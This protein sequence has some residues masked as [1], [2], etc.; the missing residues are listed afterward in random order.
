M[1]ER[2]KKLGSMLK[3][4][5]TIPKAK[6]R[7]DKLVLYLSLI[8][9]FFFALLVR[10]YPYFSHGIVLKAYDPYFQLKSTLYIITHG[11]AAWF[12]WVE[13]PPGI[14]TWYPYG[15]NMPKT[16][17]PGIP[18]TAAILYF[19][20]RFLGIEVDP[21]AICFFFP[22]FMGALASI[23]MFFL[24]KEIS[25]STKAGLLSA[26]FLAFIPGYVQ[27]TTA[28]FFD[29]EAIGILLI[30]VTL[31][32]FIRSLKRESLLSGIM[33]GLILGYLS[34]SWGA[35]VYVYDLL[36][37]YVLILLISRRYS[38][39]LL[40]SYT[41]TI[42]IGLFIATRVPRI[43]PSVL[44]KSDILPALV[45]LILL[46][47][48]EA[49]PLVYNSMMVKCIKNIKIPRKIIGYLLLTI[50]IVTSSVF[51]YLWYTGFPFIEVLE[52]HVKPISG[53]FWTVINPLYREKSRII[54]SVAEH[55]ATSWAEFYFNLNIL[56]FVYPLGIYFSFKRLKN[57]DIFLILLG[58]TATYFAGSMIRL[59]LILSPVVCLLSAYALDQILSPFVGVLR[60]IREGMPLARRKRARISGI[61]GTEYTVV[62]LIF[63]ASLLIIATY[64]GAYISY[65]YM[66]GVEIL[67]NG[68]PDWQEALMWM[69]YNLPATA[70]VAS[71][72]DY[73]YW[74]NTVANKTTI[75]DNATLNST[76]I[77][78][79]GA[80]FALNETEAVKIYKRFNVTHVLV[81]F[82]YCAQGLGGDE[83][84]WPWMVR[85]AEDHFPK[86]VN[87][88][89]YGDITSPTGTLFNSTVYKM[90]FYGE[91][92]PQSKYLGYLVQFM[93]RYKYLAYRP[94][95]YGYLS[96]I[97]QRHWALF[98]KV[99][100]PVYIS[101][102]RFVKIYEV[103][104]S[105]LEAKMEIT[106]AKPYA[107]GLFA[108]TVN[109]T[110]IH[111]ISISKARIND[112]LYSFETIN[113][114]RTV[115][116]KESISLFVDTG[117]E[118][119]IGD[120]VSIK[121]IANVLEYPGY[122][123][124]AS[125]NA[126]II[127]APKILLNV[128]ETKSTIYSNGIG[129]IQVKNVG[130][131]PVTVDSMKINS[132][133]TSFSILNGSVTLLPGGES[134]FVVDLNSNKTLTIGQVMTVNV[135]YHPV[136]APNKTLMV[137]ANISI[138]PTPPLVLHVSNVTAY[139]NGIV[140]ITTVNPMDL[141]LKISNIAVN[142]TLYSFEVINGSSMLGSCERAVLKVNTGLNLNI[143]QVVDVTIY[144]N[145]SLVPRWSNEVSISNIMVV[146]Y[147]NLS[148]NAYTNGTILIKV[149]NLGVEQLEI[150]TVKINNTACQFV[151]I[152]GSTTINPRDSAIL[153]V[154]NCTSV[155]G[156]QPVAGDKIII[157][158]VFVEG[159]VLK[160]EVTVK[161]Q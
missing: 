97:D 21:V 6:I 111:E 146:P 140:A 115:K 142:G 2:L 1:A 25:D 52:K 141:P 23:A 136:G 120:N 114:S 154:L 59:I 100:K 47:V 54:A 10:I 28:G 56:L 105:I 80:A 32:F 22:A 74:I 38:K 78:L 8:L 68:E 5:V 106:D 3:S 42:S 160:T 61:V 147:A 118:W 48:Y 158:I 143:S 122:R 96:L 37:L 79:I 95:P 24:A 11:F 86:L 39:S 66:A 70:I 16:S 103:N 35:Y 29:N 108:I 90:L 94:D 84:K 85:I 13:K 9:I 150:L 36:A 73:G 121:V 89:L 132:T 43:G 75:V 113:G 134:T 18:W 125:M 50:I 151:V 104:Y 139:T 91:P 149:V 64:Y 159:Y 129:L 30:I 161:N 131:Y 12:S 82:G 60:E 135:T 145:F 102:N 112:E 155:L 87:E 107:N 45:M 137:I 138:T 93:S 156:K 133:E 148:V 41:A 152:N 20:L 14:S 17:F 53:K 15:R 144:Y 124:Y 65:K 72:W 126:S 19:I 127:E 49:T 26:F 128:S 7:K 58:L 109:N 99:F 123:I 34:A 31:Y 116:P 92:D 130:E 67:P 119:S 63:V 101:S 88:S 76:Q 46:F 44:T 71:W 83:F 77:A 110:G 117:R 33:A 157:T 27:R 62:T 69:R 81:F 57:E 55:A 40:L 51:A 98:E 153:K 4:L